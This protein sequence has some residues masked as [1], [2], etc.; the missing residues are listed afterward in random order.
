MLNAKARL[1]QAFQS[2]DRP[3]L[4][5][6][7][8]ALCKEAI[9]QSGWLQPDDLGEVRSYRTSAGK[10]IEWHRQARLNQSHIDTLAEELEALLK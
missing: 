7:V 5:K 6:E 1:T 9:A 8:S 10:V 2:N 3:T 4:V